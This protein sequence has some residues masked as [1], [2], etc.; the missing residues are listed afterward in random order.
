MKIIIPLL[1]SFIAGLSTVFGSL[2][3]FLK[4]SKDNRNKFITFCLAFSLSVMISIS[5]TDLIPNSTLILFNEYNLSKSIL[6]CCISFILGIILVI[7]LHKKIS[8]SVGDNNLYRLGILNMLAM[9]L[10]NF[11]EGIATFMS[12]YKDIDLGIKLSIAIM[13]HN[14]PEGISIAVPIYYATNN[15]WEAIKKTVISGLSEPI[16]ALLAYIFLSKYITES[17]ISITLLFVAGLMICLS[18]EEM[19]PEALKYK[20]DRYLFLGFILGIILIMI[21]HIIS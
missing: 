11:P 13:L 18:I 21:N 12:A 9:I 7:L 8:D 2:V 17:L 14:I 16:G 19:L 4:I 10:H 3:I 20:K 6:I 1:I 15:K 5:I